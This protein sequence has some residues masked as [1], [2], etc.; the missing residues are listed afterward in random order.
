[1]SQDSIAPPACI[2]LLGG[3]GFV[4]R[5]LARQL[6]DAG[7]RVR[8]LGRRERTVPDLAVLPDVEVRA[9]GE[10]SVDALAEASRGCAALVNLV[11][12]LH[13]SA[14]ASFDQVHVELTRHA[15][16]AAQSAGVPRFIQISALGAAADAPSRYLRSK[17][18]A[19]ALVRGAPLAWTI[20]RPSVIFGREDR[21]LNLFAG[22]ARLLPVLVLP[23]PQAVFQP[24]HVE[25][26]ARAVLCCL[27]T[28]ATL[29]QVL[30]LAGPEVFTL[31]EL[32][33]RCGT[34]VGARPPILGLP[35]GASLLQAAV[36][37]WLPGGLMSRDNVRSMQRPN[38]AS[39]PFPEVLG[40]VPASLDAV[41][42][43]YLQP[44]GGRA[45]YGAMRSRAGR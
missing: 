13:E 39:G 15:L 36:L 38:V 23:C 6:Q 9:L 41:V 31:R 45:A 3:S 28:P 26:V 32:V 30:E 16:A 2:G 12:I 35:P 27:S 21:F 14:G 1:M 20:L 10:T 40:F 8:I 25:D 37:E 11:G 18:A 33:Q 4:G 44:Q 42:P 24:I 34:W 19:E 17:A 7:Y 22:L 5:A 43:R 29:G